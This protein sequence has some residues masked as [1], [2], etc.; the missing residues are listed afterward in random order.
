MHLEGIACTHSINQGR[1]MNNYLKVSAIKRLAF[2]IKTR[3]YWE[4]SYKKKF[5][6]Y[7]GNPIVWGL[8]NID[9][10]GPNIHLGNNVVFLAANG[11]KTALTTVKLKGYEG[12]I[13]IGSN[14]LVMN[15]VRISSA[16]HIIIND[17]CMLANFCYLTDADWHDVHDRTNPVGKTAPIIL[18]KAV[19][20]GDS[21]IICKGVRIGQNSVVGAGAV[22]TKDVPPNVVVAGNPAR[23]VKT[24]DPDRVITHSSLYQKAGAPRL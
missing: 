15:G 3:L 10:Y 18:E 5:A 22:V 21:A 13:D 2:N 14:V 6:T 11:S 1:T 4:L 24:I 7:A 19:W 23:I 17:D 9:I 8:W 16:T 20:I 12:R